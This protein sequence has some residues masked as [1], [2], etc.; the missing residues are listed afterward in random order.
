MSEVQCSSP[1]DEVEDAEADALLLEEDPPPEP[2]DA[3]KIGWS[4]PEAPPSLP[5]YAGPFN[6]LAVPA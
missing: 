2:P 3:G 1:E 5:W 6:V 4:G